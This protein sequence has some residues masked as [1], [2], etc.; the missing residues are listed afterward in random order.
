MCLTK[1]LSFCL[2]A[3]EFCFNHIRIEFEDHLSSHLLVT[4][5]ALRVI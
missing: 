4:L 1:Q 2:I 5:R 3:N